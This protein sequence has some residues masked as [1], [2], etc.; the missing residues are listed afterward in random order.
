MPRGGRREGSGRKAG[1]PNKATAEIKA[2]AQKHGPVI[3]AE[4]VRLATT[5]ESHAARVSAAS[6]VLDRAYG[7]SAPSPEER[8]DAAN[9]LKAVI[10]V[11][12]APKS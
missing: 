7:K 5:S 10:N 9:I 8:E 12:I 4:L 11:G 1:V 6:I 2:T 3:L